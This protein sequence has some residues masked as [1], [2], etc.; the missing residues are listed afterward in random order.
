MRL[1]ALLCSLVLALQSFA[2]GCGH[3]RATSPQIYFTGDQLA[4]AQAIHKGALDDIAPLAQRVGREGLNRPGARDMTLLFFALQSAMGEKPRQL[5]ILTALVR[6]GADPTQEAPGFGSVL[7][8]ALR[9]KSP[10]YLQALLDAGVNPDTVLGSSPILFDAAREHTAA[11]LALLLDRGAGIDRKNILGNTALMEALQG[12]QLDQVMFLLDRGASP[13]FVNINGVS[14]AGQLQ[15]QIGRQ[16]SGSPAQR[17]MLQIRDRI[18][19]MGVAWPP[20]S[21]D[22]ERQRMRERGQEP[23]KLLPIR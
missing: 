7:G 21:R 4:L 15:F 19:G 13:H 14:F 22:E 12:M 23:D 16:Q 2:A 9:A 1:R 20:P 10:L 17:R 11:T 8:V 5:Q 6:A 3:A 18:V